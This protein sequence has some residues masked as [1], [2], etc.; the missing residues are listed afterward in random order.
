MGPTDWHIYVYQWLIF[1]LNV[2]NN[3]L[4]LSVKMIADRWL[5]N[6]SEGEGDLF[7]SRI[8]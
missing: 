1:M 8:S 3:T 6:K 5:S 7:T 2:G 4:I